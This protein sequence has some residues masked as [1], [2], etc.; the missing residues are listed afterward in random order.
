[1]CC[2]L[3]APVGWTPFTVGQAARPKT[4]RFTAQPKK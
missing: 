2:E 3:A 4:A 1:M